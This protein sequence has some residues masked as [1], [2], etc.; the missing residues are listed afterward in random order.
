MKRLRTAKRQHLYKVKG[1]AELQWVS[2]KL[3]NPSYDLRNEFELPPNAYLNPDES[4][5]VFP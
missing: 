4:K 1:K 5:A 2:D 3:H